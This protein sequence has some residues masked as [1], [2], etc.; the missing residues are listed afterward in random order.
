MLP[1]SSHTEVGP[2]R[3]FR[4]PRYMFRMSRTFPDEQMRNYPQIWAKL[5]RTL[6]VFHMLVTISALRDHPEF[7]Q[8]V[9]HRIW[10]FSWRSEGFSL[11]HVSEGLRGIV[12]NKMYPFAMV[13]HD[14]QKYLGSILGIPSDLDE[15]PQYTPWIAAVWVEPAH[16]GHNIGRLLVLHAT[17]ACFDQGFQQIYLCARPLRHNFYAR[18]GWTPIETNIGKHRLTIFIKRR[19]DQSEI[20]TEGY[21]QSLEDRKFVSLHVGRHGLVSGPERGGPRRRWWVKC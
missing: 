20:V 8:T 3:A 10:D 1:L 19:V 5:K 14:G 18:Q 9:A 16:R 11:E 17:Q 21:P 13:A 12:T 2:E 6:M 7:C 15:R 4:S